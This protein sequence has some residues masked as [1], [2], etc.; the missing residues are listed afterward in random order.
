MKLSQLRVFLW[1]CTKLNFFFLLLFSVG[2]LFSEQVFLLH[3]YFYGGTLIEF[4]K[5]LYLILG[6]Y[7]VL[8]IFFNLIPYW[9]VRSMDKA[10]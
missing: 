3:A 2:L 8:W 1:Q 7:K 9:V 5:D 6:L 10:T 4:K